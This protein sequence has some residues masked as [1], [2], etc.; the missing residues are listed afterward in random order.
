MDRNALKAAS[1]RFGMALVFFS[2]LAA[3]LF[4]LVA[5]IDLLPGVSQ[6]MAK[7]AL[8]LIITAWTVRQ[9][10]LDAKEDDDDSE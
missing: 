9:M 4:A 3:G 5:A 8:V 6:L 10:Y 7:I 1:L 2:I